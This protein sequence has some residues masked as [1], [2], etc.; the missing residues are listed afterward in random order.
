MRSRKAQKS[1]L[2]NNLSPVAQPHGMI[3]E[4]IISNT[5]D[6][7]AMIGEGLAPTNTICDELSKP[8]FM[9]TVKAI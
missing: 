8:D 4:G 7:D 6:N 9:G 2:L 5:N 3:G 1:K